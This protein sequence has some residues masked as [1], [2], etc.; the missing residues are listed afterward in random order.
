VALAFLS[1]LHHFDVYLDKFRR[2]LSESQL[3]SLAGVT[4]GLEQESLKAL[5]RIFLF[6]C[7]GNTSRSPM[8]QAICAEEIA[9]RLKLSIE[10]LAQAN[11]RII[12]AGISAK[13]GKPLSDQAQSALTEL[14]ISGFR[15]AAQSMTVEMAREAEV[16]FCMTKAQRQAVIDKFPSAADKVRCLDADADIEDPAGRGQEAFSH[17]ARR[18]QD[19]VRR[20]LDELGFKLSA[21]AAG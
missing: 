16:I 15:H 2:A 6:V 10:S 13:D 1:P 20:R 8:A 7:S 18:I 14:G 12:S 17:C 3:L 4:G 21:M 11:I 5:Q 9:R 19:F